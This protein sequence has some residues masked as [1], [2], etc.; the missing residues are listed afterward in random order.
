MNRP[1]MLK[2]A[3]IGGTAFGVAGGLPLIG[4]INCLCCALIIGAGLTAAYLYSNECKTA[5]VEFGAGAGAKLGALA[6]LFY[7]LAQS[8]IGGL[9]QL[10]MGAPDPQEI[11]DQI[12]SSGSIPPELMESLER[13]I[14]MMMG[15]G[16]I[17]IGVVMTLMLALIFATIGGL[18]GGSVFKVAAAGPPS[19]PNAGDGAEHGV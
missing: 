4:A 9:V 12:D 10:V 13:Y 3:L 6:G 8:I 17:L 18:I 1:T 14:P 5:G 15:G 2:A 7:T 16:G 19:F 11:L